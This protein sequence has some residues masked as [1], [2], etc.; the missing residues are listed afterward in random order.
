MAQR[1]RQ[2]KQAAAA[3]KKR[4]QRQGSVMLGTRNV[5]MLV[6]GI[7]VILMGYLLLRAGS[8]TAAPLLLVAGYCV[9]VPLS[10]V[11]WVKKPGDKEQSGMGE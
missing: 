9:I 7:A 11:L 10:I 3:A 1:K 2:R 4:R 8:I 5:L 6:V